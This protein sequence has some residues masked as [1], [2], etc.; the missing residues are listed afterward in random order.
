M[1]S[2]Q[3]HGQNHGHHDQTKHHEPKST[4]TGLEGFFDTYLREKAPFQFPPNAREWIVKYGP[5]IMLIFVILGALILIPA[6]LI[7]LGLTAVSV[8]FA[9]ATG[10]LGLTGLGVIS[11]LLS[12]VVLIMGK[13]WPSLL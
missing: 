12:V 6:T 8:P 4:L 11:L 1:D 10:N 7:A 2:Q 9:A 3:N 13:Q 5:W